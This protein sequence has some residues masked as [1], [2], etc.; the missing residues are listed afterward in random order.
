MSS[1]STQYP[2]EYENYDSGPHAVRVMTAVIALATLFV[3]LRIGVRLQRR[4]GLAMD[5]WLAVASLIVEWAEY[6]DGYLCIKL[7]GVGRHLPIALE[8]NP[9]A[10]T[11]TFIV[12]HPPPLLF[13]F[14]PQL[15][16][17]LFRRS[18][19]LQYMFAGEL[20]FFT[21]LALIK[22]SILASKSFFQIPQFSPPLSCGLSW[23]THTW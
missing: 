10:V 13:S 4:V 18:P 9:N 1:N 5:D 3:G 8:R 15:R 23:K 7:G 22:W 19:G 12:S 20:I 11:N 14:S 21:G 6:A 17:A 16:F 2:P